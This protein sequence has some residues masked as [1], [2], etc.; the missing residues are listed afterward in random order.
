MT[1]RVVLIQS[2]EGYSISCP[3]LP[4]CASQGEA[5]EEALE[6]IKDAIREYLAAVDETQ[7]GDSAG[8][9]LFVDVTDESLPKQDIKEKRKPVKV[10][11]MNLGLPFFTNVN[12]LIHLLECPRCN[13][14]IQDSQPGED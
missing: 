14:A 3:G 10:R 13:P 7:G 5:E 12:E 11:T 2:E 6:N 8:K 1:Y 9:I 4:G